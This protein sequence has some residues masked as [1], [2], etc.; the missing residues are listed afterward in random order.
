MVT[1][2][3]D[4]YVSHTELEAL[5]PN[6]LDTARSTAEADIGVPEPISLTERRQKA[7]EAE[8]GKLSPEDRTRFET[9]KIASDKTREAAHWM[10][11]EQLDRIMPELLAAID[12]GRT[13]AVLVVD[14]EHMPIMPS[15]GP[16]LVSP[17]GNRL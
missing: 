13:F 11:D 16:K 12:L 14:P 9:L 3:P 17:N 2:L 6:R 10:L 4:P 15:Q 1:D 5:I 8:L 7:L